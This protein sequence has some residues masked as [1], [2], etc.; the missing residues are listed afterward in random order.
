MLDFIDWLNNY[1]SLITAFSGLGTFVVAGTTAWTTKKVFEHTR[2]KDALNL[3]M[4][5]NKNEMPIL[6][7]IDNSKKEEIINDLHLQ[8]Q[9]PSTTSSNNLNIEMH[10]VLDNEYKKMYANFANNKELSNLGGGKIFIKQLQNRPS[11]SEQNVQNITSGETIT[12]P[13][14]E[15]LI[16]DLMQSSF[17]IKEGAGKTFCYNRKFELSIRFYN[18]QKQ[19]L[20]TK[21]ITIDYVIKYEGAR[22]LTHFEMGPV[23]IHLFE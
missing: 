16:N 13:L 6:Y 15:F 22:D 21:V 4:N 11:Y 9:N 7:D 12:L 19:S 1:N 18:K 3:I 20:E 2:K 5:I 14:P 17:L 10:E 8:I 23:F